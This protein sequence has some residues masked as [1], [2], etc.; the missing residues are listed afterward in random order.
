MSGLQ[1]ESVVALVVEWISLGEMFKLQEL[2][3]SVSDVLR[4]WG[5]TIKFWIRFVTKPGPIR[6][7]NVASFDDEQVRQPGGEE[8]KIRDLLRVESKVRVMILGARI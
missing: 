2:S 3:T 6:A 5:S 1:M 4:E 7:K 8:V